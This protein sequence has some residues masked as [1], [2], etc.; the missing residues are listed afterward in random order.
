MLNY[1][2]VSVLLILTQ[3]TLCLGDDQAVVEKG[4]QILDTYGQAIVQI[5]ATTRVDVGGGSQEKRTDC[6]GVVVDASGLAVVSL[7][8]FDQSQLITAAFRRRNADATPSVS[9]N[10]VLMTLG[11]GTEMEAKLVFRD[12][13]LDLAFIMP[14]SEEAQAH[15]PFT[16]IPMQGTGRAR[17]LDRIII[18]GRLDE[19]ENRALVVVLNH[20]AAVITKPRTVYYVQNAVPGTPVFS[21]DGAV[22]GLCVT[23]YSEVAGPS[24]FKPMV[25]PVS[26][27]ENVVKQAQA[28][29]NKK[30]DQ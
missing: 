14:D 9:I 23:R 15:R 28:A 27:I 8:Y 4:R 3:V 5:S 22:L 13:D 16:A 7:A 19:T 12:P 21:E 17:I 20:I 2:F 26:D 25:L 1:R 10:D 6:L 29:A 11:D 30:E 24:S 18:L